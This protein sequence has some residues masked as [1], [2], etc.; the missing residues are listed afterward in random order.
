VN[1]SEERS[2]LVNLSE[3]NQF[4]ESNQAT[5][6][7]SDAPQFG[8]LEMVAAFTAMRHEWRGQT[9]ESRALVEQVES[10]VQAIQRL[11]G[12]ISTQL[13]AQLAAQSAAPEDDPSEM[14]DQA[15]QFVLR[16]ADTDHQL[17]RAITAVGQAE[18]HRQQI[19]QSQ[20]RDFE[21]EFAS[22]N[23]LA[24]RWAGGL[25]E[26]ARQ[27][28]HASDQPVADPTTE[29]LNLVLAR[30]RRTLVE[31]GV[32]RVD[33]LGMPFDANTMNAIGTVTTSDFPPGHVAEQLAPAYLWQGSCLRFADVRVSQ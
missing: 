13:A 17:T 11:E 1:D 5:E 9:K 10:A 2:E 12:Q 3:S 29:G 6:A 24:R 20:W 7:D 14:S 28:H 33:T 26:L 23:R 27:Q 18:Q 16:L 21:R 4:S 32:E 15:K 22:M 19:R 8:L 30:L 31:F 25:L